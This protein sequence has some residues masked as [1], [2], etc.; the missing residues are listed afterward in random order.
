MK[1]NV[2]TI[3]LGGVNCYLAKCPDGFVLIDTGFSARRKLLLK[4][5]RKAGC[6]PGNLTFVLITHGD[7][8]HAG[9]ASYLQE[10][11]GAPVGM[12]P[13]D[14]GM[15]Q[16]GDM[17]WNRKPKADAMSLV[18]KVLGFM[19][20]LIA[21]QQFDTFTPDVAVHD[22][23]DLSP[24]G[25]NAKAVHIPGHS[26]GSLGVLAEDGS[27]YCGDFL[28]TTPGMNFVDD[29]EARARSLS[30]LRT[31]DIKAVFPGHGRPIGAVR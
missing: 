23:F 8:D 22:G 4:A 3:N 11:F 26:K 7:S 28:Y 1:S 13:D 14:F 31:L 24:F 30:R 19:V 9:N 15:V 25:F 27:F 18:M 16:L 10:E 12:H 29:G 17:N 2:A 21:K 5:L 20:R 6:R